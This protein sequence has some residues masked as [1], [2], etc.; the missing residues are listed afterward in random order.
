MDTA[1]KYYQIPKCSLTSR[2]CRITNAKNKLKLEYSEMDYRK[3]DFFHTNSA[4]ISQK[5]HLS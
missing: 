1:S 3:D 2:N 5:A 4:L